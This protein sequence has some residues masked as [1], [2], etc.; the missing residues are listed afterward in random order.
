MPPRGL[1]GKGAGRSALGLALIIL[2]ETATLA[3]I[4]PFA[5]WNT[6]ICWWG[7]VFFLD[8]L[9]EYHT[10]RSFLVGHP[11]EFWGTCV[12]VS[13]ATWTLFDLMNRRVSNWVYVGLPDDPMVRGT[14][15]ALWYRY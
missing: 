2:S 7:Y 1:K 13:L 11:E 5:T 6:P 15:V 14:A 3:G 10:D 12:P 9:I 4:E 8:G